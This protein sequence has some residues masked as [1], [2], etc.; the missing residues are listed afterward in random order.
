M[1]C[2]IKTIIVPKENQKDV[3]ELPQEVKDNLKIVCMTKVEDA[4][5][6]CIGK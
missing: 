4:V 3:D 6:V 2:G 5:E 1:R